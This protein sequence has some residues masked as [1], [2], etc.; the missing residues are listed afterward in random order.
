MQ[1]Q[2]DELPPQA[3]LNE[4]HCAHS[5]DLIQRNTAARMEDAI[6]EIFFGESTERERHLAVARD[7]FDRHN[8]TVTYDCLLFTAFKAILEWNYSQLEIQLY[9]DEI[10][11]HV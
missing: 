9:A 3:Y 8:I 4:R 5:Q 7:Y 2:W 10:T 1:H 6:C 11:C